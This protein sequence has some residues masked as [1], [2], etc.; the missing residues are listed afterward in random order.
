MSIKLTD[1]ERRRTIKGIAQV[2]EDTPKGIFGY[3]GKNPERDRNGAVL[4]V[5]SRLRADRIVLTGTALK[6]GDDAFS[7]PLSK[8]TQKVIAKLFD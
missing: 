7:V 5:K 3:V 8:A 4:I 2:I 1:A 6:S